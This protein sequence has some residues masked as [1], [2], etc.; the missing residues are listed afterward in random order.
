M[1]RLNYNPTKKP[2]VVVLS[3]PSGVGKDAVL[4]LMKEQGKP[5]SFI[6]TVTTRPKREREKDDIDYRFIPTYRFEEM[7][8]G[9]EL[10]EWAKVY[11]NFYGVPKMPIMQALERGEDVV[12]KVDVQGAATIKRLLPDAVFIFLMPPSMEELKR[13]LSRRLTESPS[14]L[15]KRL[16]AADEEIEQQ[17]LF[18]HVVINHQDK[19]NLALDEIE[20]IIKTEKLRNAPRFY[21]FFS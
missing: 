8:A 1:K 17:A 4:N 5:F 3:G 11:D 15:T 20:A 16:R 18:D 19:L 14:A 6:T 21:N 13:R 9:E 10:I 2:L 7:I 12:L